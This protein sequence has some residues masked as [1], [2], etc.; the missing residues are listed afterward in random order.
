MPIFKYNSETRYL[1]DLQIIREKFQLLVQ[2]AG[3][4]NP[5]QLQLI[6]SNIPLF[7]DLK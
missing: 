3:C 4:L 1:R 6:I 2:S 7:T 5:E